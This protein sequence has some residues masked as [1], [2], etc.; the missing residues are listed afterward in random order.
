M[1]KR[2]AAEEANDKV[3]NKK[4]KADGC[5][6]CSWKEDGTL[7]YFTSEKME[8]NSKIVAFDLVQNNFEK[9]K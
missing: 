3:S 2:K 8:G 9:K 7:M 6:D 4:S 1:P 5:F